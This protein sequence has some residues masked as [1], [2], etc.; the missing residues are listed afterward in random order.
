MKKLA[1]LFILCAAI[2]CSDKKDT[3]EQYANY[4]IDFLNR[5][6]NI[7][8]NFL[9]M[10]FDHY[11]SLILENYEDSVFVANKISNINRF[12]HN[13]EDYVMFVDKNNIENLVTIV[14]MQNS[15]PNDFMAKMLGRELHADMKKKGE[16]QG[17]VY[18]AMQNRLIN[19]WLIKVKGEKEYK[20]FGFSIYQ[21]SYMASDFAAFV[22]NRDSDLDFEEVF[23][24]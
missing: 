24:E 9:A 21:T 22:F 4:R 15:K 12:V 2:G 7:P 14:P 10:R 16:E 3:N 1:L 19:K 18:K 13:F 17:Y 23:T 20:D 5:D 6:L 8:K 11:K